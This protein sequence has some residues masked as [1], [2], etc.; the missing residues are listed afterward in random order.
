MRKRVLVFLLLVLA[1][2]LIIRQCRAG[3]AAAPA[4]K[5]ASSAAQVM[6]AAQVKT[7]K[8]NS[9]TVQ[10]GKTAREKFPND[11]S[12]VLHTA[13]SYGIARD[14]ES[15]LW[16]SARGGAGIEA[17]SVE[18]DASKLPAVQESEKSGPA[19]DGVW[20]RLAY[21]AY[22]PA[23]GENARAHQDV[24]VYADPADAKNAVLAVQ[25]PKETAKWSVTELP[26][27]GDWLRRE[28]DVLLRVTKGY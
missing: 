27:Y 24:M 2:G 28:A 11:P 20:V 14:V 17:S 5:A 25:N 21:D 13:G 6:T 15:L 16:I 23:A 3:R 1:A 26:G 22:T 19:G 9:L 10:R 4:A 18:Q 7:G 8:L 12:D